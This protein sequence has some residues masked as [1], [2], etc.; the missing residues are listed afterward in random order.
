M[1]KRQFGVLGLGVFGSSVVKTLSE[2]DCEVL[3]VDSDL[4][5]VERVV[6]YAMRAVQADMTNI[7]Q[8]RHI[9]MGECDVVIVGTGSHLEDSIMAIMN[10]KELGVGYIVAKA[11]NKQYMTILEKIGAN[12]VV[13]PEKEAG[14]RIA[15]SLLSKN[16]VD[17]IDV[18]DKYSIVDIHIPATWAN[19]SLIELNVR[20]R[21]GINII[22]I[23]KHGDEDHLELNVT[24]NYI[25]NEDD[26]ILVVA[27][28]SS[29]E[30]LDI[31]GKLK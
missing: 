26:Q 17:L 7:D 18:D 22:G 31:L 3:A 23:R 19:K 8:L 6:P 16:I 20:S 1:G 11:K 5:C 2:Y 27:E 13:R 12:K 24:P 25:F 4:T 28:T 9:G 15:K 21:F 30:E 14:E 29:I 10:L